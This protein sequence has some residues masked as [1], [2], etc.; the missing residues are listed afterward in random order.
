MI[1]GCFFV[2]NSIP[3]VFLIFLSSSLGRFIIL[4]RMGMTFGIISCAHVTPA[5][6]ID[7]QGRSG[8]RV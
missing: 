6:V 2:K 1:A 7:S 3:L 8:G 5:F 4:F